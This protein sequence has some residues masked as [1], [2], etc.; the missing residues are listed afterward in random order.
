MDRDKTLTTERPMQDMPQSQGEMGTHY[1]DKIQTIKIDQ[2]AYGYLV[3]VGCQSF[4]IETQGKVIHLLNEYLADP[5]TMHKAWGE[6]GTE[7]FK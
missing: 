5:E 3:Q 1:S 6:K 4:A 7:I 2:L